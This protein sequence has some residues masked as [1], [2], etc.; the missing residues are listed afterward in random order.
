MT[1]IK[2]ATRDAARTRLGSL[3]Y[4]YALL[5]AVLA[6]FGLHAVF[7]RGPVLRAAAHDDIVRAI[8]DEDHHVCEM[9]GMRFGTDA[10]AACSSELSVIRQNQ[11]ERDNAAAE[12]I[13]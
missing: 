5:V 8:A 2:A 10:F 12:G 1:E 13:L 6:A 4:A 3:A 9:F 7:V 11:T